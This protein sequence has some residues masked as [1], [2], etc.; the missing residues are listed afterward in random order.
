MRLLAILTT[1]AFLVACAHTPAAR[2]A[3]AEALRS[4]VDSFHK[5]VRWKDYTGAS[6]L[7]VPERRAA[8]DAAREER[9]DERDLTISDFELLEAQ[10]APDGTRAQVTS[11][12]QW[13]RLPSLSEHTD[14]VTTELVKLGRDWFIARQN[15]GPFTPELDVPYEA[16]PP[17][18]AP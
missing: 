10:L 13:L 17:S 3:D 2:Q 6:R 16:P 7:L 11:R 8:F 12:I 5:R 15:K 1:F 9:K 4:V 14:T 18:E